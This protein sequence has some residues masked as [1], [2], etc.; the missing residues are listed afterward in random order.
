[1]RRRLFAAFGLLLGT[2]CDREPVRPVPAGPSASEVASARKAVAAKLVASALSDVRARKLELAAPEWE[3]RRVAFGRRLL[4]RLGPSSLEAFSVPTMAPLFTEPLEGPRGL[5]ELA[6]GSVLAIGA[7]TTLRVDPE[8]KTPVRLPRVSATPG[9][10]FLPERRNSAQIWAVHRNGGIAARH[11]LA[12]D[13][14]L[15]LMDTIILEGYDGGP[16]AAMK[17]GELLFRSSD[18]ARITVPEGRPRSV[19]A[20]VQP[21]RLLPARRVDQAFA[22]TADGRV[23]LWQLG[24]GLFVRR[25][26]EL[27]AQPL[28]VSS[29]GDQLAAVLVRETPAGRAFEL[30][31]HSAEGKISFQRPLDVPAAAFG[32]D[33]WAARLVADHGVALAEGGDFVAVGGPSRLRVFALDGEKIVLER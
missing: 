3:E 19:R 11:E 8:A 1:M 2:G 14:E 17:N 25:R 5:V 18:G 31:V 28:S 29:A 22:V 12:L 27:G 21:W 7:E 26:S 30:V 10:A 33:D 4:V 24:E 16:V 20:G 9:V 32:D 6:G 13:R 15:S 23:E